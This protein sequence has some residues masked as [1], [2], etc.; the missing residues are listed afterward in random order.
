MKHIQARVLWVHDEQDEITPLADVLKV[1]EE[2]H[3]NIEFM[4]TT[5]LGHK[6]IYKENKVTKAIVDFL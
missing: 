2:N 5:G 1:K 4:I 6:R 3:P